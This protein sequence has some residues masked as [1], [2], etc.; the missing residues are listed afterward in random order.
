MR[1]PLEAN[2]L[3]K[4]FVFEPPAREP[5][6][7][8]LYQE[9][10]KRATACPMAPFAGYV[11]PLWFTS[12]SNEHKAVRAAA[13]LFDCTHMGVLEVIGPQALGFLQAVTTNAVSRLEVGH[14]QYSYVLDAAGVV[15]DDVIVYR[16][17]AEAF[18]L[19]VN[20]ANEP[21]I[22]AYL[23]GLLHDKWIVD[24]ER[25]KMGLTHKPTVRDLR[26]P[27]LGD[28]GMVDVALQGPKSLEIL[29]DLVDSDSLFLAQLKPF[30]FIETSIQKIPCILSRTGYTGS[31]V[32][33]EL[34]VPPAK[35]S[36]VWSLL[37]EVGEP[38]GLV[39]C[40]LGARDSLRIEAGLPLYGHELDGP[41]HISPFGAGYGWAV[42]LDKDFFI[43]RA[44]MMRA[45]LDLAMRVAR[46]RMPGGKGVRP[47]RASDAVLDG[48]GRCIGWVL[49]C[50]AAGDDQ[51]AL[52]YVES[53]PGET[54]S[55]MGV[56]YLARNPGQIKQGRR[57]A[58][59]KGD[60]LEPDLRGTFLPRFA[61]F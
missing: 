48:E 4:E 29:E 37:L 7:T 61:K 31:A 3:K 44:A 43:G 18:L 45:S 27:A 57:Q 2:A 32:G 12:I 17:A 39:P 35:A 1:R 54:G 40:G 13:G 10:I 14:A 38:K 33:F 49:S 9:H 46:L 28:R 47:V 11:M 53:G 56:Y 19:V 20:A 41:L 6:G 55:P 16:R 50:A 5:T 21:K 36:S 23:D 8:L 42:K 58:V 25:P 26:D 24:A 51:I 52:A 60:L 34:L 59:A 15:L 30:R 22:E